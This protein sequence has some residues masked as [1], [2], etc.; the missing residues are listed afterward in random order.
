MRFE[1]GHPL[2]EGGTTDPLGP[3]DGTCSMAI[4]QGQDGI[5]AAQLAGM[6]SG[7]GDPFEFTPLPG[8]RA[9]DR[10]G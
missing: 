7:P 5:D 3:C 2:V 9:V 8:R 1:P 4:A 10:R 6:V